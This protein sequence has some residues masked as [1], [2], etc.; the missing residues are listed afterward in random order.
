MVFKIK[1]YSKCEKSLILKI[2]LLTNL[3][4]YS[5]VVVL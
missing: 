3:N 4:N 5:H 2:C 1:N